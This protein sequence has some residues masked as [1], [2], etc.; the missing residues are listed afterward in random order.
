MSHFIISGDITQNPSGAFAPIGTNATF[1]CETN[2]GFPEDVSWIITISNTIFDTAQD[3]NVA[4][5]EDSGIFV[6]S[7]DL[8]FTLTILA[9]LENNNTE[10]QCRQLQFPLS[11]FSSK[12]SLIVLGKPVIL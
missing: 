8:V 10:V 11:S 2:S 7:D 12:A 5:L 9:S 1:M 3:D 4:T 6:R